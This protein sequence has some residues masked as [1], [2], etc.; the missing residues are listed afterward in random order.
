M[1]LPGD[2]TTRHWPP[3]AWREWIADQRKLQWEFISFQYEQST[4]GVNDLNRA[5][6][7]DKYN[8]FALP[9]TAPHSKNKDGR[10]TIKSR[11]YLY[12]SMRLIALEETKP[13][14]NTYIMLDMLEKASAGRDRTTDHICEA[15]DRAGIPLRLDA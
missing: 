10:T 1:E 8:M 7:L 11:Y 12:E 2:V 4:G 13:D 3:Q 15:M 9:G 14:T 5:G 6:L